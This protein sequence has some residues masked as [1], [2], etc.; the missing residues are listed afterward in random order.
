MQHCASCQL[1]PCWLPA[2]TKLTHDTTCC[3]PTYAAMPTAQTHRNCILYNRFPTSKILFWLFSTN[4]LNSSAIVINNWPS[5]WVVHC[6]KRS[7]R[8]LCPRTS[9][10]LSDCFSHQSRSRGTSQ[11]SALRFSASQRVLESRSDDLCCRAKDDPTPPRLAFKHHSTTHFTTSL[12]VNPTA[13]S[14]PIT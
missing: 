10:P 2:H 13:D 14:C 4:T 6:G 3:L 11:L 1:I 5:P 8:A 9:A 12:L 7:Y